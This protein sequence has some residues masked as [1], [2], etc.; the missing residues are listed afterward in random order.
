MLPPLPPP[1]GFDRS[2]A[3]GVSLDDLDMAAVEAFVAR[4]APRLHETTPLENLA[5][6]IGLLAPQ[7]KRL[8]PSVT[9]LLCFGTLPQ[10]TRPEW[11]LAAVRVSGTAISD[12][13]RQRDDFEGSIAQLL[14]QGLEFARRHA[15]FLRDDVPEYPQ[16]AVRE[17]LVNA[18]VHRDYRLAGRVTLRIF[19]DRLEIWSPGAAV[20]QLPL[21][22]A[23]RYG[24]VSLPRNPTIAATARTLGLVEQ[25]GRGLASIHAS[26]AELTSVAPMFAS[27]Q[28][29]FLAVL[30]SPLATTGAVARFADSGN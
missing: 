14:E 24:G 9:G 17:A 25:I 20:S 27:T 5:A 12:A 22:N 26:M 7:G 6:R 3:A 28:G 18:L 16:V 15:G 4:R 29:D 21:E 2:A 13:L 8:V 30:P 11:G 23:S 19:D 1:A 10:L